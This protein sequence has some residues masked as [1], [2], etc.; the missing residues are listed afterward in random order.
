MRPDRAG[1]ARRTGDPEVRPSLL[2]LIQAEDGADHRGD[3]VGHLDVALATAEDGVRMPVLAQIDG[4]CGV[5]LCHASDQAHRT[6]R[7]VDRG[8]GQAVLV[9]EVLDPLDVGRI[10]TEYSL[11]LGPVHRRG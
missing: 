9:R 2:P 4:E 10:G 8:H 3:R 6:G 11:G 1:T 5:H 7:Q